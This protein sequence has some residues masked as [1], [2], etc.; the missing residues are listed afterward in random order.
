MT[1]EICEKTE[2]VLDIDRVTAR[3]LPAFRFDKDKDNH[4]E[5]CTGCYR[6]MIDDGFLNINNPN[7][8]T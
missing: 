3:V 1:C 5:C 4:M 2:N 8:A 7:V 6:D